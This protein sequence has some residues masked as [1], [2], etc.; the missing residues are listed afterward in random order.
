MPVVAGCWR[1][2]RG[3]SF[4]NDRLRSSIP[5]QLQLTDATHPLHIPPELVLGR[6]ELYFDRTDARVFTSGNIAQDQTVQHQRVVRDKD[7]L[8]VARDL[9]RAN[10]PYP[11]PD[12]SDWASHNEWRRISLED[13]VAVIAHAMLSSSDQIQQAMPVWLME[14]YYLYLN[15]T[16]QYFGIVVVAKK[17][18]F[19][20]LLAFDFTGNS[21]NFM[22][23]KCWDAFTSMGTLVDRILKVSTPVLFHDNPPTAPFDVVSLEGFDY[24]LQPAHRLFAFDDENNINEDAD[25]EANGPIEDSTNALDDVSDDKISPANFTRRAYVAR[26]YDGHISCAA[27]VECPYTPMRGNDFCASHYNMPIVDD[28]RRHVSYPIPKHFGIYEEPDD[29]HD[30]ISRGVALSSAAPTSKT[31]TPR[32]TDQTRSGMV[33][34]PY[35]SAAPRRSERKRAIVDYTIAPLP[36]PT[37]RTKTGTVTESDLSDASYKDTEDTDIQLHDESLDDTECEEFEDEVPIGD[38]RALTT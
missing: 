23:W 4:W 32:E 16:L 17:T 28:R 13:S 34:V 10:P 14:E 20:V 37:T 25:N 22:S 7:V 27:H 6:Q 31:D 15:T 38:N 9:Y 33:L 19:L 35:T 29:I 1:R 8:E 5:R 36:T 2:T 18:T 26:Y 3:E 21:T 24:L 11:A 30:A 12:I